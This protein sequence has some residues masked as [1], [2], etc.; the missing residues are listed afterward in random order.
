MQ[1]LIE[2]SLKVNGMSCLLNP[3]LRLVW[4]KYLTPL[5]VALG[6]NYELGLSPNSQLLRLGYLLVEAKGVGPKENLRLGYYYA[7]QLLGD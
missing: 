4:R 1:L 3:H 2:C 6:E 5:A 7:K